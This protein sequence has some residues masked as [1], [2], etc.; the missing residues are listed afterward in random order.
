MLG[1]AADR[2]GAV[3]H[4]LPVGPHPRPVRPEDVE[5][6]GQRRR[7]ARRSST[8]P[9]PTP[10]GSPLIHG[11]T[12]GI[13]QRFGAGQ[14]R[15]RP[16]L[17]EQALE[18]GPLRRSAPGRRRSPPDAERRLPDARHL[19]PAERWLLSRAAATTEAVD[20]AMAEYAFGEVTRLVYDAIWSEFCDWG[21][22]LAKVRLADEPLA[23]RRPRGDLVDARRGP[24]HVSPPAPPGHA[25][26]HRGALGGAAASRDAIPDLL[27]VARWPGVGERDLDGRGRG[28]RGHRPRHRDPQR[29]RRRPSSRP[30]TGSR[31]ASYVP[32]RARADVRGARARRSNGSPAPGRSIATLT[33][34]A[35]AGAGRPGDLAVD[36]PG[37]VEAAI[38]AGGAPTP[39][40]ADLERARLE[41]GLA[42]AEGWLAAARPASPNERVRRPRRPP[43]SSTAR[44]SPR[45]RAR[46]TGRRLRER[47]GALTG[48][49]GG[50]NP[51]VKPDASALDGAAGDAAHEVALQGEEH[52]DRQRPSR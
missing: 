40:P 16:E 13:D 31:H 6:E 24:R 14:A 52:D 34:E 36:R 28:R 12:P 19:G 23:G 46:R 41:Q 11:A 21:L 22:E 30:A 39:A 8:R 47:L 17:R 4:G 44:A 15:A 2:P 38:R 42:E 20:A 32:H 27:I 37:G 29:P 35:L 26:R 43:M 25:V 9:A 51:P 1:L 10:C 5:D 49:R 7:S 45:G 18:R 3:P 33:A 48:G 50:D